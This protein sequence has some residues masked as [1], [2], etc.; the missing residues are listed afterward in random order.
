MELFLP[1][2]PGDLR[3]PFHVSDALR[4]EV[5]EP[6]AARIPAS[7]KAPFDEGLGHLRTGD[8]ASAE[9]SFK[10]AIRPGLEFTAAV[11]Y[12]AVA[13]AASGHDLEAASAWQTALVG[14]S[15]LAQIY[16]WLGDALLRIR[17]F[18]RARTA[19]EEALR[20]WPA[21]VRFA[22]PLAMLDATTG[23]GYEA[24]QRLQQYLA[25]N[26]TDP[27]ALYLGVQWIYAVHLSGAT[28][29]DRAADVALA[30]TYAE[31]YRRANG[32]KQPL[33][34]EWLDYLAK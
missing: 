4:A 11:T 18:A 28:I 32:P 3:I 19:L 12:L 8:Y 7:V 25:A 22:R 5:L 30:R 20:R 26:G 9:T 31:A 6:F 16:V 14:G 13:F 10:L 1:I 24:I 29:R 15:N 23:R 21:D 2:D 27:Q 33:V 34:A 17:E